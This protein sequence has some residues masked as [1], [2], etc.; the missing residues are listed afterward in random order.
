MCVK[1]KVRG[2]KASI[3]FFV[4]SVLESEVSSEFRGSGLMTGTS[5]Q[6]TLVSGNIIVFRE[7]Y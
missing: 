3:G 6:L 5:K 2:T 4:G 7:V 1:V